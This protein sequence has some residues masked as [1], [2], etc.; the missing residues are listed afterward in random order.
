MMETK[1]SISTC[2]LF[3]VASWFIIPVGGSK[4]TYN[5]SMRNILVAEAR[6]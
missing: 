1:E 4:H 5:Y 2:F 3:S 6:G